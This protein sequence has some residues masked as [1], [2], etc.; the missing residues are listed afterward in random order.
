MKKNF[1][2][3]GKP[4]KHSL[5]PVLHNYWFEK[6]EIEANYSL[7][8]TNENELSSIVDKVRDKT[9]SGINITLLTSKK[10]FPI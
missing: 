9:Y 5:S 6:Y 2:I 10:L 8:D 3:I 1:G 7:I 4:I